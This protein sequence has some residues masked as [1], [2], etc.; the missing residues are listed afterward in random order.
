M[1]SNL[2][3]WKRLAGAAAAAT[4]LAS[5]ASADVILFHNFDDGT[6]GP[7]LVNGVPTVFVGDGNPD[8]YVGVP[9]MDFWGVTLEA[10]NEPDP[11]GNPPIPCPL[12]GDIT[13]MGPMTLSVDVRVFNLMNFFNE[14]MDPTNWPLVLQFVSAEDPSVSVYT[15]GNTL[16]P[17]EDLWTRFTYSIPDPAQ[18]ALPPGWGGTGAEDPVTYEPILPDG[19]N[20]NRVLQNVLYVRVTTMVPGY[21]YGANFW[22]VGFDNLLVEPAPGCA[23]DYNHDGFPDAIDYDAFITAWLNSSEWADI[24]NDQFVDALDYD[25]FIAAFIAGC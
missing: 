16:P 22:E 8:N 19:W 9:F 5:S 13:Q 6:T 7:W 21:F 25:Q 20:Y 3:C 11:D 17:I 18:T 23:A 15:I 12:F 24:N 14:P 4:L 2:S 1:S 10:R